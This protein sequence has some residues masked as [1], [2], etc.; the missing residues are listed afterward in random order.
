MSSAHAG[1][2]TIGVLMVEVRVTVAAAEAA[3]EAP[4]ACDAAIRAAAD[5]ITRVCDAQIRVERRPVEVRRREERDT[6]ARKR[7]RGGQ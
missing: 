6:G 1:G 5:A 4:G 3:G 7:A 2:L